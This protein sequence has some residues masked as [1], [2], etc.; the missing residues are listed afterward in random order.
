[1]I[2]LM[3]SCRRHDTEATCLDLRPVISAHLFSTEII[4]VDGAVFGAREDQ[5]AAP[6]PQGAEG[7]EDAELLIDVALSA[8]SSAGGGGS[9]REG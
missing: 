2:G 1:M 3:V 7:G 8:G 6:R 4:S 9:V 5:R